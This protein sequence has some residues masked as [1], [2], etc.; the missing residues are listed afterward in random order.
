M[1]L[2]PGALRT[3]FVLCL[4]AIVFVVLMSDPASAQAAGGANGSVIDSLLS[5]IQTSAKGWQTQVTNAATSLFWLLAAI[6]FSVAAIWLAIQTPTLDQIFAMLV[7]RI[8]FIGLFLFFLQ[9]GPALA[10]Q[11]VSSLYQIGSGSGGDPSPA[12]LFNVGLKA[13]STM[14][15][16]IQF[17]MFKDNALA[18]AGV[19][20]MVIVIIAFAFLAAVMAAIMVEQYVGL[21]AGL[22][23]LG[24]GGSTFTKDVAVKYFT[25]V[26]AIGM[27]L[28]VLAMVAKVASDAISSL[29]DS[30]VSNPQQYVQYFAIA[31][32]AL[33]AGLLGLWVPNIISG[34]IQGVS[35]SSGM[36]VVG[37]GTAAAGFA[38]GAAGLGLGGI[39]AGSAARAA[40][41]S[42]AGAV[43]AGTKAAGGALAS[44]VADKMMRTPGSHS[45]SVLGLANAKLKSSNSRG[46]K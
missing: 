6:E 16:N 11:I 44:A 32:I 15:N 2:R 33:V 26:F 36:E 7:K 1:T 31:G 20:S 37:V 5:K 10:Q 18:I 25:Y 21:M 8:M 27:K 45:A 29:V 35:V 41:S 38:V 39:A 23:M 40:G 22:I 28:L 3:L 30:N 34:V 14:S 46:G 42:R 13:V 12:N 24:F 17:G 4:V 19:F 9:Q 43:L